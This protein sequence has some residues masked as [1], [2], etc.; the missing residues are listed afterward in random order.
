MPE[1]C[2]IRSARSSSRPS[3]R[4]CNDEAMALLRSHPLRA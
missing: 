4:R 1:T 3:S 2:S